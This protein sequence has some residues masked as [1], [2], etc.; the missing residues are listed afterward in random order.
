[1]I[2]LSLDQ[3]TKFS[4]VCLS[5]KDMNANAKMLVP[6]V[7]LCVPTLVWRINH[8]NQTFPF[9]FLPQSLSD[10]SHEDDLDHHW[11]YHAG[12]VFHP[13]L[14]HYFQLLPSQFC[15]G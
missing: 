9:V 11:R 13:N 5:M 8:R 12:M 6:L 7:Q 2:M 10:K 4:K 15:L 1:M 3:I 14:P